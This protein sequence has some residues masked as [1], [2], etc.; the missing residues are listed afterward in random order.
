MVSQRVPTAG[1]NDALTPVERSG[2]PLL[3][4][5]QRGAVHFQWS[6]DRIITEGFLDQDDRP[7][8]LLRVKE[9]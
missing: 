5:W 4:T 9:N 6:S 7:R 8:S 1:T 3:R 2:I